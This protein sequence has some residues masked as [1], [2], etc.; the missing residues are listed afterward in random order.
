MNKC[1]ILVLCYNHSLSI[2]K[3]LMSVYGQKSILEFR[4]LIYDDDSNDNTLQVVN[5]YLFDKPSYSSITKI[6]KSKTNQGIT[7][8]YRSAFEII[9]SEYVAVL[10]GDD[11]WTDHFKIVKQLSFLEN[12]SIFVSCTSDYLVQGNNKQ[13]IS[14]EHR[15]YNSNTYKIFNTVDLIKNYSIGNFSCAIYRMSAIHQLDN[16]IFDLKMYDWL[17]NIAISEFGPFIHINE[18]LS[19]YNYSGSGEWSKMTEIEQNQK[20]LSLIPGYK[21]FFS[22][23]YNSEFETVEKILIKQINFKENITKKSSF[24]KIISRLRFKIFK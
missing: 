9:E 3:A 15:T 7:N 20:V 10:E 17:F 11:F 22:G 16:A 18:P 4:V 13:I 8:S 5:E 23:R 2:R 1:T 6:I 14:D 21:K 24:S 12:N 19:V